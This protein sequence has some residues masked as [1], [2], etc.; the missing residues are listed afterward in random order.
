MFYL[1]KIIQ[2]VRTDSQNYSF[3][4]LE[5]F[6][7]IVNS[8]TQIIGEKTEAQRRQ[9]TCPVEVR[10]RIPILLFPVLYKKPFMNLLI[11]YLRPF[12]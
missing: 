8:G 10:T 11:R 7:E 2:R 9:M 1:D 3:L 12:Y 4:D 5:R 6:I